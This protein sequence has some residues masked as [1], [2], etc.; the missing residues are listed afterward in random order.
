MRPVTHG[1]LA[2]AA[3]AAL[4]GGIAIGVVMPG[5]GAAPAS[6][7]GGPLRPA[8]APAPPRVEGVLPAW[9]APGGILELGG[10]AGAGARLSLV[11][12]G[13]RIASARSGAQGR[14]DLAG[15]VAGAGVEV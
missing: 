7:R 13:R 1:L 2:A 8:T 3:V 12:G 14:F 9:V 11:V 15:R 4:G 5:G 10:W 6:A